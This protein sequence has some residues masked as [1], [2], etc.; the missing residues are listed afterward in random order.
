MAINITREQAQVEAREILGRLLDLFERRRDAYAA[1]GQGV[2][3]DS[4]IYMLHEPEL[5]SPLDEQLAQKILGGWVPKRG[6]YTI[7]EATAEPEAA[8]LGFAALRD[9]VLTTWPHFIRETCA[10]AA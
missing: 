5:R 6:F 8:E 7:T 2:A 10:T 3:T 1:A 4:L 9:L